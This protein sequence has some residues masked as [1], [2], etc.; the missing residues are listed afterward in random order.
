MKNVE[1]QFDTVANDYDKQR[2]SLIPYFDNFYGI[3]IENL[4][5]K[6]EEPVLMD[7]G[8]G[9]GLF[10]AMVLR[11]YPLAHIELIDISNEML[12]M[13]K[14]RLAAYPNVR[15]TKINI[16]D[17]HLANNQYDVVISS[18]AIHHL[19]DEEKKH[20]SEDL[21]RTE[22]WRDI[23]PCRTSSCCQWTSD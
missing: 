16:N 14:Q 6:N 19:T 2:K 1:K 17:I 15:T 8:T 10:S 18:L 7:I 13:S 21:S 11:K 9:T 20:I 4:V 12:Q 22:E 3:A 5:L 23:P